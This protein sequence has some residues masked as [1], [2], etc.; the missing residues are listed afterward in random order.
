MTRMLVNISRSHE[1]HCLSY[2]RLVSR[3]GV[4]ID[5]ATRLSPSV[6][7]SCSGQEFAV[8]AGQI[9]FKLVDKHDDKD[10]PSNPWDPPYL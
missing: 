6:P 7:Q 10:S 2:I 3:M 9:R 5:E 1:G 4:M 8:L